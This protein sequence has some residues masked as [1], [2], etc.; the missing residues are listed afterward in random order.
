MFSSSVSGYDD[1][2]YRASAEY[3]WL[4]ENAANYGFIERYPEG[5][6]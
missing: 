5:T 3:Q 6:K 1:A 2:A 4:T